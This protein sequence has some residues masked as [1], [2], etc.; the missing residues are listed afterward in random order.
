MGAMA[1]ICSILVPQSMHIIKYFT[2][3]NNSARQKKGLNCG[4]HNLSKS[5]L[6]H[7]R[8][9]QK[10]IQ[11]EKWTISK[12]HITFVQRYNLRHLPIDMKNDAMEV[13][14]SR[15]TF[16][17]LMITTEEFWLNFYQGGVFSYPS[18]ERK[19]LLIC[20]KLIYEL[21]CKL[22]LEK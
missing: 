19:D 4:I 5:I 15:V 6:G 8:A 18:F 22:M 14:F 20:S 17:R 9:T 13:H 2:S 11:S 7:N 3:L 21:F 16:C 1:H 10:G 12:L